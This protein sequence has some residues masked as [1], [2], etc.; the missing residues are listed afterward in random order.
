MKLKD[1]LEKRHMAQT[2]FA[3]LVGVDKGTVSRWINGTTLPQREHREKIRDVTAGLVTGADFLTDDDDESA[4][5]TSD[6]AGPPVIEGQA[7]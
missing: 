4:P 7:A 6:S 3:V 5:E 1:W 2:D